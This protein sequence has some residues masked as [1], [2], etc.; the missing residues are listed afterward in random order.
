M[1]RAPNRGIR[2]PAISAKLTWRNR[3]EDA[4]TTIDQ[5][6]ISVGPP[7]STSRWTW[8]GVPWWLLGIIA[9]V[10]VIGFQVLTKERWR[11]G[12]DFISAGLTFTLL[13]TLGGFILALVL[14][15]IIGLARLSDNTVIKNLA[16]YYIE[17][18]RGVPVLVTILLISIVGFGELASVIGFRPAAVYRGTLALGIIYAAFIAEV[19]RAGIQS[20]SS[21][22]KEAGA[23]VGMARSQV[24]R[25][26]VLPQ[27]IRNVMPALGN[28]LIALLK[29]SSLVSLIA[30]RELTQMTKL[31]TGR[32]FAFL[33]GYLILTGFYL[34]LTVSLSLLLRWYEKRIEVP[35]S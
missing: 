23:S 22:Q 8:S 10:A 29:D 3:Q 33:E 5:E 18:I 35:G 24:M 26:I 14:G 32:S 9:T 25:F 4:V 34:T 2:L 28:D 31:W 17:V 30:V 16:M 20:I 6:E 21:G 15:L 13:V 12:F 7:G 19:F 27:A 1:P 11:E